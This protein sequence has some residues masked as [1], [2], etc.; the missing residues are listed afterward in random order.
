MGGSSSAPSPDPQ[1]G[2]AALKQAKLGEDWLAISKEQWAA[3]NKRNDTMAEL[4]KEVSA[5]Q[6]AASRQAQ[7][8]ASED[9]ARYKSVYQ[10]MQDD[11]ISSAKTWDS[12]ERQGS[13]AAE[14][15]ADVINNATRQ[16]ASRERTM[17]AA[18]ISPTSGRYAG[19]ER[20]A[21]TGTALAAA[22]AENTAR[23]AVRKEA[24]A[25]KGD[26]VNMGNGLPSSAA[27]SLGLGVS[28]GS[29][30]AGTTAAGNAG[31]T[32]SMGVLQSG[33]GTA[34]NGYA[35][36]ASALNGLYGNQIQAW[37]AQQ[38]SSGGFMSALGSIAGAGMS[39]LSSK[40]FKEDKAPVKGVLAAVRKMPVEEWSYK[41][42]IADGGRH[43]GP[44]A[45]DFHAATGK[46]DG[47]VIPITDALGVAL[48]AIQ[49]LDRKVDKILP[50]GKS[51]EKSV[52]RKAA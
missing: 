7:E 48:G 33:Y 37:Q 28:A 36:Q 2:Q 23:S 46:G 11:L 34:M 16:A 13:V 8:W 20:A 51:T 3:E 5:E 39:L 41:E 6:L 31:Y 26:A 10:P 35:G 15:R 50:R 38:Q 40:D 17:A 45:E 22:G 25:L 49:E 44:Y 24:I 43:I 19:V 14:A 12:A 32:Q 42:G 9:R 47:K 52:I 27:S 1:I 21:D 4:T 18:G 29:T 30:A